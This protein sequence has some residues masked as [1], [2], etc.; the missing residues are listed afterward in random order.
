[1]KKLDIPTSL[2]LILLTYLLLSQSAFATPAGQDKLRIVTGTP[3][4]K[5]ESLFSTTVQWRLDSKNVIE[6]TGLAFIKGPDTSKPDNDAK[7]ATKIKS[8]LNDALAELYPNSRGIEVNGLKKQPELT[9]SNKDGYSFTRITVRDYSNGNVNYDLVDKP[10]NTEGVGVSID[11]VYSADVAY[12]DAFAPPKQDF[13]SGGTIKISIDGGKPVAIQ[14]KNKSTA[15]I[16]QELANAMSQANY[17][18]ASII[19]HSKGGG[20]RNSKPF[21]GGE[22]QL[23]NLAARS[24]TIDLKDPSL[25]VLTKFKFKDATKPVDVASP[26]KIILSLGVFGAFGYFVFTWYRESKQAKQDEG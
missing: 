3:R 19:P 6:A 7:V 5:G 20:K 21:D 10:F 8:G 15:V 4:T 11:L 1:M 13:A 17:S 18:T 16:E 2:H 24:F 23:L 14:T 26:L 12:L 9:I 25:G 22:I